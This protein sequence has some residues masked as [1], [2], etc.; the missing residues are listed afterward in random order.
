[1]ITI[2]TTSTLFFQYKEITHEIYRRKTTLNYN[3]HKKRPPEKVM[4]IFFPNL[5][6]G[7]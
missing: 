1:M 6:N 5:D 4:T 3:L 2:I 7:M